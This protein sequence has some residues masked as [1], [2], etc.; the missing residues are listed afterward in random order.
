[1][2]ARWTEGIADDL[3]GRRRSE[4]DWWDREPGETSV[5]KY[6]FKEKQNVGGKSWFF[7]ELVVKR[8]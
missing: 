2:E 4:D 1:M 3:A 7:M 5:S 6:F 8:F